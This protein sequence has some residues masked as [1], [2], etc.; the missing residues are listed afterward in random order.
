VRSIKV[1]VG[2]V[3]SALL[4]GLLL[5]RVDLGAVADQLARTHPGWALASMALAPLGVW[6]R[7][8][9]WR[10]LYPPGSNPPVLFRA[11]MIGYMANNVLPLRAGEIVRVG[12]VA[13]HWAQGFWLPM[14]TLVVERVLDGLAIVLML[15]GLVMI[16]PVPERLRWA[17]ALFLALDAL[18]VL[19][20]MALALV[21]DT[22]R[23]VVTRL[24]RRWSWLERQ[25]DWVLETFVRGLAGVKAGA[26]TAPIV[27]WSVGV[28]LLA[29]LAA[30]TAIWA[31]QLPLSTLRAWVAAWA[32][33]AFVGLGVSVP[34]APGYIGVFHAAAVLAL[35]LVDV[36]EALALG[37][38]VV[39]HACGF[40][41]V[42]LAGW[43][44]LLREHI[45][46]GEAGRRPAAVSS[47][48][49]TD[50]RT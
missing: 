26:H 39:F 13:R 3:I 37:Y 20:L 47:K 32:V 30:L 31:A 28:W 44:L 38:A 15:A 22:C 21:P 19:V 17:A 14:A 6:A 49:L 40:I 46:L 12:V 24:T 10:Y 34:S 48:V 16:L 50:T 9:R 8:R 23:A 43:I 33:V 7:A 1:V 5:W 18:A 35:A 29:I 42:T 4:I 2:L 41:P 45:S 36:P 25:A 27:L 11:S